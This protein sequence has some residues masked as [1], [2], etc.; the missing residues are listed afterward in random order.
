MDKK[1]INISES[2]VSFLNAFFYQKINTYT[3]PIRRGTP[4]GEPIG[5]S[6]QKYNAALFCL[7]KWKLKDLANVVGVSHGLLRK[8][9]TEDRYWDLTDKLQSEY[10]DLLIKHLEARAQRQ[11]ELADEYFKKSI[12]EI[13]RTPPPELGWNEFRDL[14][15]YS[16]SLILLIAGKV[17]KY[18]ESLWKKI[19][20]R[21]DG[22]NYPER[23]LDFSVA[24]QCHHFFEI[25]GGYP[26]KSKRE[27]GEYLSSIK[28]EAWKESDHAF[29]VGSL[30]LGLI[31]EEERKRL[32]CAAHNLMGKFSEVDMN[33]PLRNQMIKDLKK[34]KGKISAVS[35]AQYG[36]GIR[37]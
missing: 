31:S 22:Y 21:P 9:R 13:A 12:K 29:L 20:P 25:L 26:L 8:W 24:N 19:G 11:K 28:S 23:I 2:L 7:K 37:F 5:F 4:R 35:P 1:K 27:L 36:E 10:T 32:I 17:G 18:T 6:H 33:Y 14:K 30:E 34:Y 15:Q 3:E 16:Q